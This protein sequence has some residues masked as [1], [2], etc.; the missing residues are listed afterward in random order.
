MSANLSILKFKLRNTASYSLISVTFETEVMLAAL[1]HK[2][3]ALIVM[4]QSK[5]DNIKIF[6][7]FTP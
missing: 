6:S 2:I 1:V 3:E 5:N 7:L 4:R